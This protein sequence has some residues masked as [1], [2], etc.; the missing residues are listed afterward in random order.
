[1]TASGARRAVGNELVV[2]VVPK[3]SGFFRS[4]P[5]TTDSDHVVECGPTGKGVIGG[6]DTDK[7]SATLHV[8]FECSFEV[9]GPAIIRSVI[10]EDDCLVLAE[11][12]LKAAEVASDR[13]C[14]HDVNLK[15]A[16]VI[17][18]L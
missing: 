9:G 10:V 6:M 5:P 3:R 7:T 1:M 13:R 18:F 14:G 12:R 4:S 17:E 2:L 15:Q 16:C 8:F 11:V